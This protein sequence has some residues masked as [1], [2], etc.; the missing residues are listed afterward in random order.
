MRR[1]VQNSLTSWRR[2]KGKIALFGAGHLSCAFINYFGLADL[3]EFVVDDSL[4][5]QGLLMPGSKRPIVAPGRL[6]SDGITLCL[7]GL[8]PEN[9]DKIVDRNE[10]FI[11]GGGTFGSI[12]RGSKRGF[13]FLD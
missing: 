12:L 10:S 11:A 2:E 1:T 3:I 9:E 7:F 8:A 13:V 5:K 6:L 4:N